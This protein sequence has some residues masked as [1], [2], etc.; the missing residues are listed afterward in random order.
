MSGVEE[1]GGEPSSGSTPD[2]KSS[3]GVSRAGALMAHVKANFALLERYAS[4][5]TTTEKQAQK[6]IRGKLGNYRCY[7][8]SDTHKFRATRPLASAP[9]LAAPSLY[10]LSAAPAQ[11]A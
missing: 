1:G 7:P 3:G 2:K 8:E 5:V 4:Y 6:S 11:G 10:D 9:L